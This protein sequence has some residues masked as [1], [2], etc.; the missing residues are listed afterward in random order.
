MNALARLAPVN[1]EAAA[2]AWVRAYRAAGG[3]FRVDA[4]GVVWFGSTFPA[5]SEIARL[6]GQLDGA[7]RFHVLSLVRAAW[8]AG[9]ATETVH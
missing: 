3:N 5:H 8:K 6:Q 4:L 9:P 7:L 2:L 1:P